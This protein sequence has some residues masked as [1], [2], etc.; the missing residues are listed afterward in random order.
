MK[1]KGDLYAEI[2]SLTNLRAAYTRVLRN[3]SWDEKVLDFSE[4][5]EENLAEIQEAFIKRDFKLGNYSQFIVFEP[6][7]RI[8]H[9]APVRERVMHHAV[10]GV[11][12]WILERPLIADTYACRKN[13]GQWKAVFRAKDFASRFKWCLKLDIRHYFDS[14][15]HELLFAMLKRLFKEEALLDFWHELI[16]TYEVEKGKGL[17]IGNL[18]SQYLANLYLNPCDRFL[19][20]KHRGYLRYMDDMLVFGNYEDLKKLKR[21]VAIFVG[22]KLKLEI[23]HGGSLHRAREGVDF[24]GC[25]IYPGKIALNKRSVRRFERKLKI[26]TN[27]LKM[28]ALSREKFA[29]RTQALISFTDKTDALSLRRKII[30]KILGPY[31]NQGC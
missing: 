13:F 11:T 2:Y 14:V 28:G 1:R 3:H 30:T 25:R 24:L 27:E 8:I 9:A 20:G 5:F 21:E 17:P 10:I 19:Q 18:T 31:S 22:E 7:K 16:W 26:Y 12:G 29:K 6:K 15:D 4:N 23:K